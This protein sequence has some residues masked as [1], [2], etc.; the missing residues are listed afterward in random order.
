VDALLAAGGG[1]MKQLLDRLDV[2]RLNERD[3][4]RLDPGGL[5]LLNLNEE[6]DLER[7]RSLWEQQAT[8]E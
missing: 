2:C 3:L 6:S 7:A 1:S 5:S 8:P 4:H